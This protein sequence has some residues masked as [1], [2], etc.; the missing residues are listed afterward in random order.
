VS[1]AAPAKVMAR[2]LA[3]RALAPYGGATSLSV[4]SR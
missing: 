3:A 1:H 2:A 4:L